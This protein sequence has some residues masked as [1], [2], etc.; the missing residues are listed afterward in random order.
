MHPPLKHPC[1]QMTRQSYCDHRCSLILEYCRD[2][3]QKFEGESQVALLP[4]TTLQVAQVHFCLS[5]LLQSA[6]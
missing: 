2:W 5:C 3:M 4:Q 1:D 6:A